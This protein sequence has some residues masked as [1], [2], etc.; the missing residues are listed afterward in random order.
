T[1]PEIRAPKTCSALLHGAIQ[2][3]GV[4]EHRSG[5]GVFDIRRLAAKLTVRVAPPA[6]NAAVEL[7]GTCV[8]CSRAD[9]GYIW[10]LELNLG[11]D[12]AIA[13]EAVA[14]LQHA[15]EALP[16]GAHELPVALELGDEHR[17]MGMVIP[18][19]E[20]VPPAHG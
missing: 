15:P 10:H 1:Q 19:V 14:A 6:P 2:A 16:G 13:G 9:A 17:R 18:A 4:P 8:I 3:L 5:L 12:V 20:R 7:C 11:G